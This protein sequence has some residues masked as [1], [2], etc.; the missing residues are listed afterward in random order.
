M[1]QITRLDYAMCVNHADA[2]GE[3]NLGFH[4]VDMVS[5]LKTPSALD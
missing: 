3:D 4:A 2:I 5:L 1:K